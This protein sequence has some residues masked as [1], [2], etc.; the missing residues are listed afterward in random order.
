MIRPAP[1]HDANDVVPTDL[2]RNRRRT[3]HQRWANDDDGLPT[4]HDDD[5]NMENLQRLQKAPGSL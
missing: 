2:S 4:Q 3:S 1:L 5:P